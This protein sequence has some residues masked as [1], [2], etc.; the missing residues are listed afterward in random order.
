MNFTSIFNRGETFRKEFL[1]IGEARSL[2]PDNVRMMA[3]TATATRTTRQQICRRLGMVKPHIVT[4]SPNRQNIHYAVQVAGNIE[5][6]FAPLIEEI[7]RKRTAMDKVIIFCRTY[8]ESS[9]IYLFMRN[10]LSMFGVQP[11]GAPDL[12]QF[13]LVD[14]FTACTHKDVKNSILANFARP[15]GVLRVVVATVAFGMGVDC[16]DVRRIIHWGASNDIEAYL[17][18]TGRAGR[19]GLPAQALLFP[20]TNRFMDENMKEYVHNKD[21]CRRHLLLQDFD[22]HVEYTRNCS[23]CDI[24]KQRCTCINCCN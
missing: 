24:C 8:D 13:R 14:L 15:G 1:S 22:G 9:R 6:T 11:I 16:P 7:R 12:A 3:L 19:D 21:T 20:T 10:W 5:E 2:V 18:E 17:Q 23:C 4:E